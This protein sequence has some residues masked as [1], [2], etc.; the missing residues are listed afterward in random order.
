MKEY[1]IHLMKYNQSA[2]RQV[3][4]LLTGLSEEDRTQDRKSHFKSLQGI[5]EHIV[6]GALFFQKIIKESCPEING[7]NH[8]YLDLKIEPGKDDTIDFVELRAA[9]EV[10]DGAFVEMVESLSDEDLKKTIYFNLPQVKLEFSLG[11]FIMQYSNHGTHHRGQISQ[12]LDE[13]GIENNF[14]SI[15]PHYE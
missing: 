15:A 7:L 10:L 13:M 14:S 3:I 12:I 5:F 9:L 4:K 1:L 2:D 8:K 11:V 6:G